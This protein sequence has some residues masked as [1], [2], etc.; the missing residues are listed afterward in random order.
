MLGQPEDDLPLTGPNIF[1]A[2][3]SGNMNVIKNAIEANCDLEYLA[4][5]DLWTPL[6]RASFDAVGH[7]RGPRSWKCGPQ[8]GVCAGAHAAD[9]GRSW[10]SHSSRAHA[11]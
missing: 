11:A 10:Q 4:P 2:V 9:D 5:P 8:R 7:R 1:E 3:K 6:I